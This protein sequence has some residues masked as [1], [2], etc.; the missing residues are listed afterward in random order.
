MLDSKTRKIIAERKRQ[1]A[2]KT[3][4]RLRVG[5]YYSFQLLVDVLI[6]LLFIK[7][8]SAS[9]NFAHDV[10]ADSSK[11][12]RDKSYSTV[13]ISPD[14]SASNISEELFDAGVIKNK[15]VMM[16]KIK[17]NEVGGKIKSGR[18]EL[19]PSMR[20]SEIINIIT[21]GISTNEKIEVPTDKTKATITDATQIHDNSDVGAGGGAEGDDYVPEDGGDSGLDGGDAGGEGTE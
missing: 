2:F 10:F 12:P 19:S 13:V 21:G 17:V 5:L 7:A 20:Y 11:D 6:I 15:Y 9:F 8:F 1:N 4:A 14:S 16:A 18:Y 3:E